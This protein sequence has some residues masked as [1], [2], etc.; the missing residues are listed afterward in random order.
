[1]SIYEG[2]RRTGRTTGEPFEIGDFATTL[3]I[4]GI[5]TRQGLIIDHCGDGVVVLL[6]EAGGD[7][8]EE[9]Y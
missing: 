8:T 6:G 4:G 9:L 2:M 1:M 5:D 3:L 7:E